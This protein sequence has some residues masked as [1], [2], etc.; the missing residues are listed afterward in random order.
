MVLI[1]CQVES[2]SEERKKVM[3][4]PII[5]CPLS[6]KDICISSICQSMLFST[7]TH[8]SDVALIHF[9]VSSILHPVPYICIIII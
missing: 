9:A 1:K 2:E 3:S 7:D 4:A 5:S 8:Y 6:C